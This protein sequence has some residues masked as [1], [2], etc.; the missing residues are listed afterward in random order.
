MC[1]CVCV[2]V[3]VCECVCVN[4]TDLRNYMVDNTF[5]SVCECV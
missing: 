3:S 5:Y 2:C 1:E 4:L